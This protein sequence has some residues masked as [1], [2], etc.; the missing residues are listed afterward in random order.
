MAFIY[1]GDFPTKLSQYNE[2]IARLREQE[3]ATRKEEKYL[4]NERI[5]LRNESIHL[6]KERLALESSIMKLERERLA[7]ESS[8]SKMEEERGALESATRHSKQERS[9]LEH[10]KQELEGERELLGRE[11][12]ALQEERERWEETRNDCV[13]QGAFWEAVLPALEC[14][15][16]GKRE[17]WG[18]LRNT[19]QGWTDLYACMN[20]PV[21]INGVTVRRPDRCQHGEGS[22]I[23]G[24]WMVDWEEP[25][26]KPWLQNVHDVVS[27]V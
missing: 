9:K 5:A 7:L 16:Y 18:I 21:E 20:M 8:T 1:V 11:R 25:G 14:H 26:C 17:Y 23:Q 19:P 22:D 13:P 12:L 2:V 15:A 27:S 3:G 4:E 6:E 10:E 24:F